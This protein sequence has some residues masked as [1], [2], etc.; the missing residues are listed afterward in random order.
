[1]SLQKVIRFDEAKN[2]GADFIGMDD[3]AEKIK[4]GW[5]DFDVA[6]A[7]PNMMGKVGKLARILGPRRLMPNPKAGTITNDVEK[8][9][10]EA[11]SRQ[12]RVSY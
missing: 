2:A 9:V 5:T 1:L 8:A 10:K 4:G 12:G 6:I 7:T 11:K 3:L